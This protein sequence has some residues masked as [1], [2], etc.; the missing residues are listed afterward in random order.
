M[1]SSTKKKKEKKKDFQVGSDPPLR[2]ASR[3]LIDCKKPKL[4]VG[5]TKPK[6]ANFTDTSFKSR[7]IVVAQQ[8]LTED[9]PDAATLFHHNLSLAATSRSDNQRRDALSFLTGQLSTN[10]PNNPVGTTDV[11]AKLL[12]LVSDGSGPVRT[13]LLKLLRALPVPEVRPVA[14]KVV[15]YARAGLTH[16]SSEIRDDA[17]NVMEWLLDV[18]GGEVVACPGGWMKTLNSF[19]ALMGWTSIAASTAGAQGAK[20]WTSAPKTT[21]GATK[22]GQSYSR[23]LLVLAKFLDIGFKPEEP[24]PYNPQAYWV[25]LYRMPRAPNPFGYLNLFGSPRD[26]DGEMYADREDRQRIFVKKWHAAMVKGTDEAKKEGGAVGRAAATL[27][28]VLKDGIRD[29]AELLVE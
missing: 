16:L 17:L 27:D 5:K 29:T 24:P 19:G 26:E 28:E 15:L 18:A 13:Q 4:K 8:S 6:A 2:V 20:G 22:G 23:Q 14:E 3:L 11:L 25:G 10:P 21:F 7:A 9:A 12:P 1:G